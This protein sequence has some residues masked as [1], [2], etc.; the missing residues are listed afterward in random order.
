MPQQT[1]G[2]IYPSSEGCVFSMQYYISLKS[3][4]FNICLT[5]YL[6]Y[7]LAWKRVNKI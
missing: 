3:S 2:E 4:G 6:N 7:Y 1:E 5:Y